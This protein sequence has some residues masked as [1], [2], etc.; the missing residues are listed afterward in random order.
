MASAGGPVVRNPN[1]TGT[2]DAYT[3]L[4]H[5]A[6]LQHNKNT[7]KDL[8]PESQD[9]LA[10]HASLL[11]KLLAY[12]IHISESTIMDIARCT[13]LV[14]PYYH[15][16]QLN[17]HNNAHKDFQ[18]YLYQ[19]SIYEE[20]GDYTK[21]PEDFD[22]PTLWLQETEFQRSPYYNEILAGVGTQFFS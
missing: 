13:A 1:S 19:M 18:W 3:L 2:H 7:A 21:L 12:G 6:L 8:Q 5:E 17:M 4:T 16:P 14:E 20:F 9:Q 10:C 22:W 11:Q 15:H